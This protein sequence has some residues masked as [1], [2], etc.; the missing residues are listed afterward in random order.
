GFTGTMFAWKPQVFVPLTLR[1]LMQPTEPRND[2][3][4][5]AYWLYLSGRLKPGVDVEQASNELNRF[6][7]GVLAEVEA[8]LLTSVSA[9]QMD[10]FLERRLILEPGDRGHGALEMS[11]APQLTLLLG[12]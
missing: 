2:E 8:P 11:S 12:A 1:W 3:D 9:E 7:R 4:R 10:E 5:H 6:Y